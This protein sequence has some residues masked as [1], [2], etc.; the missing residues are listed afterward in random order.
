MADFCKQCSLEIFTKDFGDLANLHPNKVLKNGY[1][2]TV[3]CEGCGITI[4]NKAGECISPSCR[5]H[6]NDE[7][8]QGL[9]EKYDD[10]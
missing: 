7:P 4:V 8:A 1:G 6:G 3:I 10:T 9:E 5:K 2:W